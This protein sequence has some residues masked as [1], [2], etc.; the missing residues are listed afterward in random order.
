MLETKSNVGELIIQII[1]G[2]G[3]CEVKQSISCEIKHIHT[4]P[5]TN[6]HPRDE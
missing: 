6:Y 4:A 5:L 2:Y 1:R 3:N